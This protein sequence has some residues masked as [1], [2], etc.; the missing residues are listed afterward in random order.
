L[1]TKIFSST[2]KNALTYYNAGVVV[3][4]SE[5]AGSAPGP[6]PTT[7]SYNASVVKIYS[8]TNSMER[9]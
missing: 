8:A 9:F 2:L 7:L 6:N 1:N 3:I 5:I 4:N